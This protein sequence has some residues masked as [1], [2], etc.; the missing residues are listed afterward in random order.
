MTTEGTYPYLPGGVSVWCD[1]LVQRL[2]DVQ[3]HI[4]A[5]VPSPKQ[6]LRFPLPR[7]VASCTPFPLWG[8][9]L[10]G[11]QESR[12]S[13]YYRRALQ[14]TPVAIEQHFLCPF[15]LLIRS[16]MVPDAPPADLAKAMVELH[17]YFAE[18]DYSTTMQS[19]QAWFAFLDGCTQWLPEDRRLNLEEATACM[20]WLLRYLGIL[21]IRYPKA[22]VVHSSIAG[23]AGVPGVL[24]RLEHGTPYVLTEHGI[25]FRE[26]LLSL[27]Q[28][29]VSVNCRRFL[30][31]LN[32][33]IVRMNYHYAD[34]VTTL[35]DF[36]RGWQ[37]RL[38]AHPSKIVTV[39][40]GVDPVKFSPELQ[41][42]PPQVTVLTLARIFPLKGIEVLLRAIARIKDRIPEVKFRILGEIADADYYKQCKTIIAK[43]GI[44]KMIE[45]GETSDPA[46]ALAEAHLF[47]LPSISEGMPYSLL[48][49]MLSGCPVVAPD[50]GNV[51]S[52]LAGKGFLARPN[53]PAD[54]AR[55]LLEALE[56]AHAPERRARLAVEALER[57][58]NHY[59]AE[60]CATNISNIY[61]E[62]TAC[63]SIQIA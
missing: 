1:Q 43:N 25:Y 12:F 36:N 21:S 13:T 20:R 17:R 38:G 44:D 3:F 34:L 31:G 15:A 32:E 29:G 50:V 57:A 59:T 19:Q 48:E 47:C 37:I 4:F 6:P 46:G 54:L 63:L 42:R 33:A 56:G 30:L 24:A 16:I 2:K 45:W 51:A 49:A 23:L 28:S 7:N 61:E 58:R 9:N 11:A 22:D 35:G 60:V 41:R 55:A 40:N 26:L 5:I 39:P 27:S 53:D 18:Y 52:V 10:P 14:T 62:L 8:T